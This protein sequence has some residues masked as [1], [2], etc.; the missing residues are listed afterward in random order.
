[1]AL[2]LLI[3]G[4]FA[5]GLLFGLLAGGVL[6]FSRRTRRRALAFAL[7]GEIAGILRLIEIDG[8]EARLRKAARGRRSEL[9]GSK[10]FMFSIPRAAIFEANAS[11]LD[12][13]GCSTAREVAQFHALL[14]GL[15]GN[16]TD[17]GRANSA[18]VQLG[19]ALSLGDHILRDLKL[20]LRRG[21]F[22]R[23]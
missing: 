7:A 10:A 23:A 19:E 21:R 3:A 4:S 5:G 12:L 15:G 17:A 22:R 9:S 1:M 2:V 8:W 14:G 13:L 11:T 20:M 6:V 18:L 16:V